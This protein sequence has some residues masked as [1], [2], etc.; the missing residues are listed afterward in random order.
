MAR[1]RSDHAGRAATILREMDLHRMADVVV[2]HMD[3]AGSAAGP[4]GEAEVVFLADKLVQGDRVVGL[5]ERFRHR[6]EGPLAEPAAREAARRRLE[7]ARG[8]ACRV[9][10]AAGAPLD[11]LLP[12]GPLEGRGEEEKADPPRKR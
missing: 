6:L 9:E 5:A 7:T 3:F 11:R 12:V 4:L 10:A 8:I 2:T 1:G